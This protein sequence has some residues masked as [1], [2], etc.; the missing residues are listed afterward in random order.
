MFNS[1]FQFKT[2]LLMPK[3]LLL[4]SFHK[5]SEVQRLH[6]S[7]S[8]DSKYYMFQLNKCKEL[9]QKDRAACLLKLDCTAELQKH[10]MCLMMNQKSKFLCKPV[11]MDFLNC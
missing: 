4:T 9:A 11:K 2:D 10:S 1:V 3:I 7:P 5:E 6:H 8:N